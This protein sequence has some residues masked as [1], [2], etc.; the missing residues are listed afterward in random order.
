MDPCRSNI[1]GPDPCDPCGVDAYD[2]TTDE[3]INDKCV[4]AKLHRYMNA[5]AVSVVQS[6]SSHHDVSLTSG[7]VSTSSTLPIAR[8]SVITRPRPA[9]PYYNDIASPGMTPPE[10]SSEF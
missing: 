7:V 10:N 1:G 2:Y 5:G 9:E 8:C 4:K 3:L 6:P